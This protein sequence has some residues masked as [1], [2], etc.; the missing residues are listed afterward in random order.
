MA[1]MKFLAIAAAL[2]LA[3]CYSDVGAPHADPELS[4][5][6]VETVQ[7]V[8]LGSPPDP[9]AE[10]DE[11]DLQARIATQLVVRLDDGRTVILAYTG[12]RRFEEGQRVRVHLNERGAFVL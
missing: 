12:E 1:Q 11:D 4:S 10:K 2:S 6:V 5:G 8:P 3:A 7:Q 9:E